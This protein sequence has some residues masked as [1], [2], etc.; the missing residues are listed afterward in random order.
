MPISLKR[1]TSSFLVSML[2]S[3]LSLSHLEMETNVT[4][5]I[6]VNPTCI[7]FFYVIFPNLFS[8]IKHMVITK[9]ISINNFSIKPTILRYKSCTFVS[10]F[11]KKRIKTY[12]VIKSLLSKFGLLNLLDLDK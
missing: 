1:A 7:N 11:L 4:P 2:G 10:F 12:C 3:N 5:N 8:V 6:L 9:I